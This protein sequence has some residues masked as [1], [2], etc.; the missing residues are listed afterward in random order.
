M[1]EIIQLMINNNYSEEAGLVISKL[2]NIMILKEMRGFCHASSSILYVCLSELGLLPKLVIGEANIGNKFF[3]H[4]WISL[5]G[6]II[7]LAI[8]LPLDYSDEVGPVILDTDLLKNE[9]TIVEYGNNSG[10][11]FGEDTKKIIATNFTEY[12]NNAPFEQGLWTFVKLILNKNINI[13]E[14]QQKY[15]NTIRFFPK[16]I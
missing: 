11:D 6:K 13:K 14:L 1:N 16:N 5:D 7:D 12:M 3:D 2:F 10:Q 4:S 8:A 9:K 15:K